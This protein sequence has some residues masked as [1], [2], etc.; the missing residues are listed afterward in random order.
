MGHREM[1]A[2]EMNGIPP[3]LELLKREAKTLKKNSGTKYMQCLDKV[4]QGYGFGNFVNA[5]R[6]YESHGRPA[7]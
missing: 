1:D 7:Q 4:A 5:V 3:S 2:G 6:F